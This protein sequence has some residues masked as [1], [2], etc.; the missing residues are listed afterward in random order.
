MEPGL[1]IYL[2][3][4]APASGRAA[5]LFYRNNAGANAS[6][7]SSKGIPTIAIHK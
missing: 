7:I 3:S 5:E 4:L 2:L 6:M 1:G